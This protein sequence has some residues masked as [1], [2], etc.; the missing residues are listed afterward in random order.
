MPQI[1]GEALQ[2]VSF[3]NF[4]WRKHFTVRM[5]VPMKELFEQPENSGLKHI[6]KHGTAD[7]AVYK[8]DT[9]KLVAI[10]EPGGAHHYDEKQMKN[11]KRKWKLCEINGVGCLHLMNSVLHQKLS[12][13][14]MRA[15]IGSVLFKKNELT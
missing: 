10:I 9:D 14:K 12:K 8:R 6:W 15:L 5:E 1:T 3:I 2:I 13:R 4:Q 11:D 7:I